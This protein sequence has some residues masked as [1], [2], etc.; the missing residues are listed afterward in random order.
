MKK[1]CP[2]KRVSLPFSINYMRLKLTPLPKLTA[3]AH[4]LI[5]L[6]HRSRMLSKCLCEVMLAPSNRNGDRS[7]RGTHLAEREC[8]KRW[9]PGWLKKESDPYTPATFLHINEALN[10]YG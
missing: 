1:N 2:E 4:A 10:A 6:K 7:R 8:M 3:R 9:R 5:V